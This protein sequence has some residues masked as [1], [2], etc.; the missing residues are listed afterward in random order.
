[1]KTLPLALAL[2]LLCPAVVR[3]EDTAAVMAAL[4]DE[5]SECRYLLSI[6]ADVD[7][8]WKEFGTESLEVATRDTDRETERLT[9]AEAVMKAKHAKKPA[10]VVANPRLNKIDWK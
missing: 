1:M 8:A 9:K 6:F 5:A 2:A 3:A 4:K 7:K 10:C